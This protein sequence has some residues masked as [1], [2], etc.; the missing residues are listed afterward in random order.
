MA[1]SCSARAQNAGP[2]TDNPITPMPFK[3]VDERQSPAGWKRFLFGEP[4]LFSVLL[5][6]SPQANSFHTTGSDGNLT[7]WHHISQS[8]VA[9]YGI[10][11]SVY[12]DPAVQKTEAQKRT[13]YNNFAAGFVNGLLKGMRRGEDERGQVLAERRVRAG[14]IEGFERDFAFAGHQGRLQMF[15]VGQR[16]LAL[17]AVWKQDA[18]TGNERADFFKSLTLEMARESAAETA[19]KSPLVDWKRY[20]LG[21]N[22]FSILL[23]SAPQEEKRSTKFGGTRDV[24]VTY[25]R[26]EADNAYCALMYVPNTLVSAET[27][28]RASRELLYQ[29][30]LDGAVE[31]LRRALERDGEHVEMKASQPHDALVGGINGREQEYKLGPVDVQAQVALSHRQ[32]FMVIAMWPL[33]APL[34]MREAFFQSFKINLPR[35]PGLP[36]KPGKKVGR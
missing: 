17:F 7:S 21:D 2:A 22:S 32:A 12:D 24:T 11:Y 16:A 31:G 10:I 20:E 33:E 28:S 9:T 25:Y 13:S 3:S 6:K 30:L 26:A 14:G 35:A 23:P 5:P 18:E 36:V 15:F 4:T 34:T 1:L 19:R 29:N 27:L 8:K